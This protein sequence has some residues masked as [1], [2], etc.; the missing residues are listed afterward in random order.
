M[1]GIIDAKSLGAPDGLEV[2]LRAPV[3]VVIT[4][5]NGAMRLTMKLLRTNV[6]EKYIQLRFQITVSQIPR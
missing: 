5:H 4:S 3:R 1:N 6:S 2:V